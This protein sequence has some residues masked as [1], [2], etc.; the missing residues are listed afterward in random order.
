MHFLFSL[1]SVI[2]GS[3]LKHLLLLSRNLERRGSHCHHCFLHLLLNHECILLYLSPMLF[4]GRYFLC[5]YLNCCMHIETLVY[6][7]M[8][9]NF[10]KHYRQKKQW[11]NSLGVIDFFLIEVL[12]L[13]CSFC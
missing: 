7:E 6:Q 3:I 13:F 5:L 1:P 8:L 4:Y 12:V 11:K 2:L 9:V 10:L